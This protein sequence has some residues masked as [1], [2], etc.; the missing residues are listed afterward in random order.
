MRTTKLKKTVTYINTGNPIII[1]FSYDE[2]KRLAKLSNRDNDWHAKLYDTILAKAQLKSLYELNDMGSRLDNTDVIFG[3]EAFV[4]YQK[5]FDIKFPKPEGP[6][7][8][9]SGMEFLNYS[10]SEHVREEETLGDDQIMIRPS[11]VGL[12]VWSKDVFRR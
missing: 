5:I 7:D 1:E 4:K 6:R 10:P 9:R 2:W 11:A 8:M 12:T 3:K